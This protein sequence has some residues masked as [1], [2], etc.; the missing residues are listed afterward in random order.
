MYYLILI[1]IVILLIINLKKN[2]EPMKNI[3]KYD[4]D[5]EDTGFV[6]SVLYDPKNDFANGSYYNEV[7]EI[8]NCKFN[9]I[10]ENIVS[11][12]K[13]K[14]NINKFKLLNQ[15]YPNKNSLNKYKN[16]LIHNNKKNLFYFVLNN[17]N[18]KANN[19]SKKNCNPQS[20]FTIKKNKF[21]DILK[22]NQHVLFVFKIIIHRTNKSYGF[23]INCGIVKN[24]IN[25]VNKIEIL[26]LTGIVLTENFDFEFK[27]NNVKKSDKFNYLCYN[28]SGNIL[29]YSNKILCESKID[30]FNKMKIESEIG[31]WDKLCETNDECPLYKA[32]KN[33]E[34]NFGG[35]INGK[36]ELPVNMKNIVYRFYSKDA[37][38]KPFC[39]NCNEPNKRK[40]DTCCEEQ[41]NIK[42]YPNLKSPDYAFV[43]DLIERN[44]I[45]NR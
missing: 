42:K 35:C 32:N 36:C 25:N 31:Y 43:N 13:N 22:Y 15:V 16:D 40:I 26:K 23:L 2:I 10:L 8:S 1:F 24:L 27:F 6:N 45:K 28:E 30:F 18:N 21:I 41:N 17:I 14:L 34:N 19:L 7:M 33:Y 5:F 9:N 20:N 12:N 11:L 4:T 3:G 37:N 39:H 38:N 44:I 29:N